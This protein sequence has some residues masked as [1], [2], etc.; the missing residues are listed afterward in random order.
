MANEFYLN[1]SIVYV[2]LF[3][4]VDGYDL[5]SVHANEK[6]MDLIRTYE[7]VI[8]DYSDATRI[9]FTLQEVKSFAKLASLE[10]KLTDNFVIGIISNNAEHKKMIEI[11]Q[12]NASQSGARVL[13]IDSPEELLQAD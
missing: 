7:K 3:D 2:R 12:S 6:F 9:N 8:Y 11:Y 1:N 4:M 5:M 13:I 10:A